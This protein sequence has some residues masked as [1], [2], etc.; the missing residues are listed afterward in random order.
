MKKVPKWLRALILA[1][2]LSGCLPLKMT[3]PYDEMQ[4][5]V[6]GK[7]IEYFAPEG[8]LASSEVKL[9]I[10]AEGEPWETQLEG[11][12]PCALFDWTDDGAFVQEAIPVSQGKKIQPGNIVSISCPQGSRIFWTRSSNV[13][14]EDAEY[15]L[16]SLAVYGE[17]R[18]FFAPKGTPEPAAVVTLPGSV[19][20]WTTV[21]KGGSCSFFEMKGDLPV[22]ELSVEDGSLLKGSTR[23][24][25][26]CK[27]S[28]TVHWTAVVLPPTPMP[29]PSLVPPLPT[30]TPPS[31]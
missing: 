15:K 17:K 14:D 31:P 18:Y 7:S 19:S 23:L 2:L 9:E 28:A 5:I 26:T 12:T 3:Q 6:M 4:V 11:D 27:G 22:A 24:Q 29:T 20:E 8:I 21:I 10:P 30:L 25:Y 1:L 16:Q 13:D